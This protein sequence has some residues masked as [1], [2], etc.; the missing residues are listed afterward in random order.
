MLFCI[1][2]GEPGAPA[3]AEGG[4]SVLRLLSNQNFNPTRLIVVSFGAIILLGTFLL[5]LPISARDGQFTPW[6]TC[7]FTATS[8][9]CVTGLVLVDSALHWTPFGQ[10]VILAMIQLGGLGFVSLISLIPLL[11]RRRI[12]LSQRLAI[13]SAFN[14]NGMSGVVRVVRHA[15]MGT[16]LL[17]G[18][19]AILLATRFVPLFGWGRGLWYSIFHSVSAF[20]NAG[21]DLMGAAGPFSSLT[22]YVGD[23]LV[24]GTIMGL[25]VAGGIGYFT[26]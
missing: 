23:P 12:G 22:N 3:P 1:G 21:F 9:T 25:I 19:G 15:L 8:A 16:F 18:C 5:H 20:C 6:L 10:G 24:C 13:A 11:L 4:G 14:L 2:T 26:W 17:E 7:L